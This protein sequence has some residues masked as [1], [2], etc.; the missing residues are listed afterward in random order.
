M[1]HMWSLFLRTQVSKSENIYILKITILNLCEKFV[2]MLFFR[3]RFVIFVGMQWKRYCSLVMTAVLSAT[4]PMVDKNIFL[5][6]F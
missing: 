3:K 2:K 1:Y 6:Y 5:S 4:M